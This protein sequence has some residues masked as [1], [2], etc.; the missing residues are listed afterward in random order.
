M[1]DFKNRNYRFYSIQFFIITHPKNLK[2]IKLTN[3]LFMEI[4]TFII[5]KLKNQLKRYFYK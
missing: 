5:Y 4:L 3:S 1:Q 2:N